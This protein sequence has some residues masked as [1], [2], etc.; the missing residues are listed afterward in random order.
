MLITL[1]IYLQS[2]E[3]FLTAFGRL[4][5][6]K[7]LFWESTAILN[8]ITIF[9]TAKICKTPHVNF[10]STSYFYFI[11]CI[12]FQC[13]KTSS[14]KTPLYFFSSNI[15]YFVQKEPIKVQI[16]E[17]FQCSG[18][19]LPNFSCQFWNEKSVP[20]KNF[21]SFWIKGSHQSPKLETFECSGKNLP[22]SSDH[23]SNHKLLS[24]QIL[25]LFFGVLKNNSSV[26]F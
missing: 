8:K 23:F 10:E 3:S 7:F 4:S 24:L 17:T 25:H 1:F 14:V 5:Y 6:F 26:L 2:K 22:S 11:L 15:I 18:Q 9:E 16:F 12:T 13:H 20:L 19:N 21:A